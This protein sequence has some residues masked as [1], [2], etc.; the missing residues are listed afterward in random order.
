MEPVISGLKHSDPW[1]V[2][3]DKQKVFALALWVI[4]RLIALVPVDGCSLIV[5]SQPKSLALTI[6]FFLT[7]KSWN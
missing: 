7:R 2:L 6:Q 4:I 1:Y 3:E 5:D